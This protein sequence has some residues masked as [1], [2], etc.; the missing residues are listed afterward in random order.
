[1]IILAFL[2]AAAGAQAQDYAYDEDGLYRY[3]GDCALH[4]HHEGKHYDL[5]SSPYY[6]RPSVEDFYYEFSN[7]QRAVLMALKP[8]MVFSPDELK[9]YLYHF[10]D[11]TFETVALLDGVLPN[12]KKRILKR[13]DYGV[14]GGNGGH[15]TFEVLNEG[16]YPSDYEMVAHDFD[17]ELLFCDEK[18]ESK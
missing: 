10:D 3:V 14:G 15:L 18:Y 1:M 8:Y 13:V 9:E 5:K 16:K 11:V 6:D 2:F 7:W 12:I 4:A 17:G